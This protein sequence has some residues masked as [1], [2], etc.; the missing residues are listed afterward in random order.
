MQAGLTVARALGTV[1]AL[2]VAGLIF[3]P[4]TVSA[5]EQ[6]PLRFT[7][8]AVAVVAPPSPVLGSDGRRHLVYEVTVANSAAKTTLLSVE[9]RDGRS[10]RLIDRISPS[11]SP[12][13]MSSQASADPIRTLAPSQGGLLWF[14]VALPRNASI[15]RT[16]MHTITIRV[17]PAGRTPVIQ[18]MV[19][20]GRTRV[21]LRRPIKLGSPLQPRTYVNGNGCCTKS[22]HDRAL[23]TIDGRRYLSQR[24]AIDW[25]IA[26]RDGRT[27]AG[28]P[29][30]N[31]SY[32]VFGKRAVAAANGVVADTN[33]GLPDNT[34]P[35]PPSNLER[36][37]T[38]TA[39]GNFVSINAGGG[40]F[41]VYCHLQPGSLRVRKGQRVRA[42]DPVGLVGN[43]GSSTQPH[44]HFM[45]TD[46]PQP[47]AANGRPWVFLF[48]RFAG[49]VTNL[50]GF[51]DGHPARI[52]PA[53]PPARRHGELPLQ[54]ALVS[55]SRP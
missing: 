31:T 17:A 47:I 54:G 51:S 8:W 46:G 24:Y 37:T 52:V 7:P 41:L 22:A 19:D 45:V 27:Y 33:D 6:P 5:G 28:D 34:P 49:R 2:A 53:P 35:N 48:W 12:D 25:V 26:G 18:H 1:L 36:L 44:L 16:L 32:L 23:W 9:V 10:G 40:H 14:D 11:P 4:D 20:M 39:L 15:P 42:G 50:A 55:F 3:G 21:D 13:F 43:S 30:K 38:R 29:T